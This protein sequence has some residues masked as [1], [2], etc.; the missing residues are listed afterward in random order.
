MAQ[1]LA[2]L[3]QRRAP[4]ESRLAVV[5][6]PWVTRQ[7]RLGL[8]ARLGAGSMMLAEAVEGAASMN[9]IRETIPSTQANAVLDLL[10][11]APQFQA[12]D[13]AALMLAASKVPLC[14]D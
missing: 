11:R 8:R 3:A 1:Q 13:A 5:A 4:V 10:R 9:G 12:G 6:S 2:D 14:L 7:L